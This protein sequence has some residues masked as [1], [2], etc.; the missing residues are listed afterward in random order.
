MEG[1][2]YSTPC[3]GIRYGGTADLQLRVGTH[4]CCPSTL[5]GCSRKKREMQP[6]TLTLPSPLLQLHNTLLKVFG[7]NENGWLKLRSEKRI[8]KLV[9][10][11]AITNSKT[12]MF[13]ASPP[14]W[15]LCARNMRTIWK[16]EGLFCQHCRMAI[17]LPTW[18]WSKTGAMAT[19]DDSG[20]VNQVGRKPNRFFRSKSATEIPNRHQHM[21][22]TLDVPWN[23]SLSDII[24]LW[25][26]LC[27]DVLLSSCQTHASCMAT[28][29]RS[30]SFGT[31]AAMRVAWKPKKDW[32]FWNLIIN[33]KLIL[34]N[35]IQ[36]ALIYLYPF[37]WTT[38]GKILDSPRM[39]DL[40]I[41]P[42]SRIFLRSTRTH[43]LN[44]K[45]L[46]WNPTKWGSWILQIMDV[47]WWSLH[48]FPFISSISSWFDH[49]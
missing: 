30:T 12:P 37:F 46:G 20:L 10:H 26:L 35:Y 9:K 2:R 1:G 38:H 44:C 5:P 36:Y 24:M 28:P 17:P 39:K 25:A 16:C 18:P 29:P 43:K 49:T 47:P 13:H 8:P 19:V 15:R 33:V 40:N 32:S 42:K 6:E 23:A 11:E 48:F 14:N 34:Y 3:F 4:H 27:S 41:K 7:Y 45:D 22:C 21:S 31:S